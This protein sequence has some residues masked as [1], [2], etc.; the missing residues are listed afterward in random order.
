MDK[1][2]EDF[3]RA[4]V[5]CASCGTPGMVHLTKDTGL[6]IRAFFPCLC[7][8]PDVEEANREIEKGGTHSA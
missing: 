6:I 4:I 3:E 8:R 2:E 5:E 1:P 7:P